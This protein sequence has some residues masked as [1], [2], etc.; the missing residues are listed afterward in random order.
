MNIDAER[1]AQRL[2]SELGAGS[3][4]G[5]AVALSA[6]AVDGKS[7]QLV[8]SPAAPEQ[9]TAV[10]R[11][12]AEAHA[13]VIPWGAG[14]AVSIG[15]P[16]HKAEVVLKLNRMNRVIEHDHANLTV[17]VQSGTTLADLQE[18]LSKQ[19]QFMPLDPPY[20]DRATIG[21]IIAANLNGP[22]RGHY[23]SIRDLVTGMKAALITGERIKAGGKVV[24]N[25]AGYDMCK[26]FVGSLG[27][28]GVVT[29]VTLRVAPTPETEATLIVSGDLAATLQ[30]TDALCGSALLPAAVM[31][32]NSPAHNDSE[33]PWRAAIRCEGF[34]ESVARHLS[35]TTTMAGEHGLGTETLHG[36]GHADFWN[37]LQ[38]TPLEPER[39]VFRVTVPRAEVGPI[40][41]A[42]ARA[43]T[44]SPA[45]VSDMAAGTV[46]FSW[47]AAN[48][49]AAAWPRLTSLATARRGHAVIFSAPHQFK[50]GLDV[51]GPP[52]MN[53]TL[54]R[55]IKREF[56]PQG[57]LNPGR[58]LAGI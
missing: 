41:G 29:E 43:V 30:F 31:L 15:N 12:C 52:P 51:W 7:P 8:C 46:W 33:N 44:S 14:T 35:E 26:L 55:K 40:I 42:A 54:M 39:Y 37:G 48:E 27:T 20:A 1:V 57:L 21:G 10:L 34:D 50:E 11:V 49:A 4:V 16:P 2:E 6:H 47:P 3:V 28:L 45:V 9:V 56:D 5:E 38:K 25:V 17:A 58:F 32:M 18:I 23:G 24:K 22:R 53:A 13:A 36:A 19:S